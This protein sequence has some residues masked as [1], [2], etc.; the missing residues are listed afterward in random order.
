MHPSSYASPSSLPRIAPPGVE[1]QQHD[2]YIANYT[3]WYEAYIRPTLQQQQQQYQQNTVTDEWPTELVEYVDRALNECPP[4][5]RGQVET[6][7]RTRI[8][9]AVSD[10]SLNTIVW[11][12]EPLPYHAMHA[13]YV[14][15]ELQSDVRRS[16]TKPP[17]DNYIPHHSRKRAREEDLH[18]PDR[19]VS[20]RS[21][22]PSSPRQPLPVPFVADD[23]DVKRRASRFSQYLADAAA[24][25]M[26]SHIR[27]DL[28]L[29]VSTADET[30]D[31]P[32]WVALKVVGTSEAVE[33][34]YLRLTAAP[35]PS[36]VRSLR[37]LKISFEH[38]IGQWN[39]HHNYKYVC[40]QLKSIRQDLTVQ[41]IRNQFTTDVYEAH[42]RISIE[43][44]DWSEFTQCQ[45]VLAALYA[46]NSSLKANE[47]EFIMYRI[48]YGLTTSNKQAVAT[49]VK[50]ISVQ[51]REHDAIKHALCLCQA[52]NTGEFYQ[53]LL[54]ARSMPFMGTTM[55]APLMMSV[56]FNSL[57]QLIRA[58]KP[59]KVETNFFRRTLGFDEEEC[60]K[61]LISCGCVISD[62]REVS[63]FYQL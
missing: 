31:E 32:D 17:M 5:A 49:V 51:Q 1:Q 42:A 63:Y 18:H 62:N 10:G 9:R 13:H 27:K 43:V 46:D 39:V 3:T 56:R 22:F 21:V 57:V 28:F 48:L 52:F 50:Q 54:L 15:R 38:C 35:D 30:G 26:K 25:P 44:G 45:T 37:A 61:F 47:D 29:P 55:I 6:W 16:P 14:E 60:L 11:R 23:I 24:T 8:E 34:S 33:K 2:E 20:E 58:F 40:D 12:N 7:L 41:Q 59:M 19:L 4:H 53:F 36:T